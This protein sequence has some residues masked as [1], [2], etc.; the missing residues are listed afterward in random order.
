MRQEKYVPKTNSGSIANQNR[1][2]ET[3][4][5]KKTT[6]YKALSP[7]AIGVRAGSLAEAIA[8]AKIGGFGGVE[9]SPN[10]VAALIEQQGVDSVRGLFAEAGLQPAGW[11]LPVDWRG[12]EADWQRG[13]EALPRQAQAAAA[14][15]GTRTMTWIMPCSN[16]RDFEAN[17]EFHVSRFTP[18]A[19]VLHDHGCRLGLEFIG[20]KT[21][22]DSQKYPFVHTMGKML[23]LGRAIGP[24]VGLLLDCWHWYTSHGTLEE[25]EA[26]R[27][28]QVVYVHVNDAPAGI[29]I[30]EQ[31]DNI[32]ALPGETGV[33][34]IAGFLRGLRS[35]G[36][37]GPVTP[38]PF[39]KELS[40]LPTHEARLQ[41][42]GAA[43]TA[44]FQRAGL[45]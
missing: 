8:A 4:T 45:S 29:P 13:L 2:A 26:L 44:I 43:M 31:R 42:V 40:E 20:P 33:I 39:K 15:G 10:E 6:M 16:D 30:D 21:L 38:E 12:E 5:R 19:R 11:G 22:R 28:E 34:D 36:Y 17:W 37:T 1:S 18:I 41:T 9:F 32:R 24:N 25:I 3:R 14:I 35:I 7:G 27:P 23:E